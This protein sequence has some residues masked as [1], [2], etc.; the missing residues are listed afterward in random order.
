MAA[1]FKRFLNICL[2]ANGP[3]DMPYSHVL[4]RI[5]LALYLLTAMAGWSVKLEVSTALFASLVDV[6][7]LLVFIRLAL[8]VSGKSARFIQ[9]ATTMLGVGVMFQLIELPLMHVFVDEQK[10]ANPEVG[11]ILLA[12]YSWNLA[13]YAHIFRE[14]LSIRLLA[15]FILILAYVIAA[16]AGYQ[17]LFPELNS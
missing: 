6:S 17:F 7:M 8:S 4:F 11:F 5:L 1:L 13:V 3:Q 2:L 14:A 16:M 15:A 9:T 10:P 12:L